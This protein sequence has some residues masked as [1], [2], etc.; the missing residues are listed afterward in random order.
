MF[1]SP[2][3]HPR[4][5]QRS[6]ASRR[7]IQSALQASNAA[8]FLDLN[9]RAGNDNR[10]L[11][12]DS[13]VQADLVKVNDEELVQLLGWFIHPDA[14][15]Y[16]WGRPDQREAVG[17]LIQRFALRRLIVTRGPQGWASF[18]ASGEVIEGP[19]A[20]VRVRDTVGAGDAFSSVVPLGEVSRWPLALTLAR[21]AEFAS[22]V[23]TIQGAVDPTLGLYGEALRRWGVES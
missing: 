14:Q 4:A 2:I 15:G 10:A 5:A 13:L 3:L 16:A 12:A 19:S 21:A 23:C 11:S 1:E 20:P 9:L 7:A 8:R 22:R 6:P 17:Q 18:D